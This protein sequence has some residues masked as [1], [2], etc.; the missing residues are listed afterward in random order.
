MRSAGAPA[1]MSR[2]RSSSVCTAKQAMA[3][4]NS[5]PGKPREAPQTPTLNGLADPAVDHHHRHIVAAPR[6]LQHQGPV[7]A[8]DQD[9]RRGRNRRKKLDTAKP[10]SK[11]QVGGDPPAAGVGEQGPCARSWP[12]GVT[13]VTTS[14]RSSGSRR[15]R[16]AATATSPTDTAWIHKA[17]VLSQAVSSCRCRGRHGNRVGRQCGQIMAAPAER[18]GRAPP[19]PCRR[20]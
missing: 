16:V 3:P 12:V 4:K 8:F 7:V 11:R 20:P 2:R 1:T 17:A 15:A 9:Q 13:V 19:G 10:T 14:G 5:R 18:A 6:G